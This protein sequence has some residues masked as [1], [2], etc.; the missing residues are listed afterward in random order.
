MTL[1]HQ[2]TTTVSMPRWVL[3]V[4]ILVLLAI[5]IPHL[6]ADLTDHDSWRQTDTATIARNFIEEPNI[7]YPRIN[8]GAPGPGYV[9]T[10]FQ[11]YPYAVHLVYRVLGE[12]P[13]YGRILSLILTGLAALVMYRLARWYGGPWLSLLTTVLFLTIPLVFRYSRAF[14]P[15]ALV[16]LFYLLATLKY[17]DFLVTERWEDVLEAAASMALAILVKPT[18]IHLGLL[19]VLLTILRRGPAYLFRSKCLVFAAV[20]L[21]PGLA[22]YVHAMHLHAQYGNT[23]GVI[24]GGD[25]KWGSLYYWT[26]PTFYLRWFQTERWYLFGDKSGTFLVL[27]G[28]VLAPS[29]LRK[30]LLVWFGTIVVY[31]LIVARYTGY[32]RG[33]QYHVYAAPAVALALT[34]GLAGI[35]RIARRIGFP[36]VGYVAGCALALLTLYA[37]MAKDVQLFTAAADPALAAAGRELARLSA[38]EDFVVVLSSSAACDPETGVPDNFE[39]PDVFFHA[40]RR[41]RSLARDQLTGSKLG[42]LLARGAMW[43]VSFPEWATNRDAEFDRLVE[44][45]MIPAINGQGFQVFRIVPPPGSENPLQHRAEEP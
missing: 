41:G 24:S 14:M 42:E 19:L 1:V 4:T 37:Y 43:Y 33:L 11:L 6:A 34:A 28:V 45:R 15:E 35:V 17:L 31:H 36:S 10:E 16:L 25:S 38:P 32:F 20:S 27:A 39:Q 12:D 3:Y 44:E 7:L 29:N 40:D 22:Y 13:L 30:L 2:P 8:W 9:E 26:S 5:R 23:F 18:S 21:L